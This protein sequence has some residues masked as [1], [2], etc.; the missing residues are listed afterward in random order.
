MEDE[1]NNIMLFDDAE[2]LKATVV[3]LGVKPENV[4]V[5]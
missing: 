5:D 2:Q 1:N 3:A 4:L